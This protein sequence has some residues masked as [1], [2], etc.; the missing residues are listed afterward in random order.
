VET[1]VTAS[2]TAAVKT[3]AATETRPA[4]VAASIIATTVVAPAIEPATIATAIEAM[5][6]RAGADK[7]A[8]HEV[9]RAPVS[10]RR[11]SIGVIRVVTPVTDRCGTDVSRADS[12]A[13][14]DLRVRRSCRCKHANRK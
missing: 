3:P 5:E 13:D 10:I 14:N 1:T 12:H 7:H 4:V 9:V 8:A 11:A 2:E 6:P